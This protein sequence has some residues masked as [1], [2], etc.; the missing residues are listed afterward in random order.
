MVLSQSL[1]FSFSV[2]CCRSFLKFFLG[3]AECAVFRCCRQVPFCF[4][5]LW[6]SWL[7]LGRSIPDI[8]SHVCEWLL[9]AR[10]GVFSPDSQRWRQKRLFTKS[11]SKKSPCSS[12]SQLR[13][14]GKASCCHQPH[15]FSERGD[16]CTMVRVPV[17]PVGHAG[18]LHYERR[19]HSSPS[20]MLGS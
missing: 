7:Y 11:W 4:F 12:P 19:I 13:R 5:F 2:C 9:G 8:L 6:F 16:L 3:G 17:P 15:P 14:F 10:I 20:M 1:S 18:K